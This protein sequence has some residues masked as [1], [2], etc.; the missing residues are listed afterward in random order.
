MLTKSL[1]Y[2]ATNTAL[3]NLDHYQGDKKHNYYLYEEN[4]VFSILPWDYNMSFGGY[5]GGGGRKGQAAEDEK[6]MIKKMPQRLMVI[7]LSL[8]LMMMTMQN[9]LVVH[10]I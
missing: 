3:V 8:M 10:R 2:F 1:R 7:Q 9:S 6:A 5:S 4:G